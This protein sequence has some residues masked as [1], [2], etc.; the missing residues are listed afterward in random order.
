MK[1]ISP[2][3]KLQ[4]IL[5]LKKEAGFSLV[6]LLVA[7]LVVTLF[8]ILSLE[9]MVLATLGQI[10]AR[11]DAQATLEIQENLESIRAFAA[12]YEPN[13]A[14][15]LN[16]CANAGG[17]SLADDML[18]QI[19]ANPDLNVPS[20]ITLT[21]SNKSYAFQRNLTTSNTEPNLV[22]V[23][24]EINNNQRGSNARVLAELFTE[25]IPDVAVDCP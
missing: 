8:F 22:S 11:E 15:F 23:A 1:C 19:R 18:A 2:K 7:T 9:A 16:L 25:V 12:S 14:D 21:A 4:A 17:T 20:S 10:R 24:Y 3:I 6:E 5:H 13:P